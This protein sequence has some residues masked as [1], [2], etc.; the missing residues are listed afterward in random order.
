MDNHKCNSLNKLHN[1]SVH[2]SGW[3]RNHVCSIKTLSL[4]VVSVQTSTMV[5]LLRYSRTNQQK[6]YI[7]STA[8]LFA[9]ILKMI[10]SLAFLH[11]ES[12]KNFFC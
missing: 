9:E 1:D 3:L 5:L 10:S 11:L 8:V 12:G 2:N 6:P 7:I 4:I